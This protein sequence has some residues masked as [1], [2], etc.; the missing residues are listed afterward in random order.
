MMTQLEIPWAVKRFSKISN[1]K[2]PSS[3]DPK[4]QTYLTC[5]VGWMWVVVLIKPGCSPEVR[6]W[7]R[8]TTRGERRGARLTTK[9]GQFW[10][11]KNLLYF[12]KKAGILDKMSRTK[13]LLKENHKTFSATLE[14]INE[15]SCIGMDN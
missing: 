5:V 2:T 6:S 9:L 11:N 1:H 7:A 13:S 14:H 15:Q 4:T 3:S 8:R 10:L 12:L